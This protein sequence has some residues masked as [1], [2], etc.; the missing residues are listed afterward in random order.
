MGSPGS[1]NAT[2]AVISAVAAREMRWA[3]RVARCCRSARQSGQSS[4][5]GRPA[6]R[7]SHL[8]QG[9]SGNPPGNR[10]PEFLRGG[11]ATKVAGADVVAHDRVGDGLAEPLRALELAQVIEHH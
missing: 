9:T 3:S 7:R 2:Y 11:R 4:P 1:R 6:T 5:Q 8:A 10:M